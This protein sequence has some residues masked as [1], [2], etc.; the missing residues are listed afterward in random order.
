MY[1]NK[2]FFDE[3]GNVVEVE[4]ICNKCGEINHINDIKQFDTIKSDYCI[5]SKNHTIVCSKCGEKCND[6]LV[7]YKKNI[8]LKQ[9]CVNKPYIQKKCSKMSNMWQC[10]Y[11]ENISYIKSN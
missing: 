5:T 9:A 4:I 11:K 8:S 1:F 3:D 7:E 6:G 2:A 10:K